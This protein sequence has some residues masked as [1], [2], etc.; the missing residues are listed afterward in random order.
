MLQV[1]IVD[2]F[3]GAVL[4]REGAQQMAIDRQLEC[5]QV[6]QSKL[7]LVHPWS[8]GVLHCASSAQVT[9]SSVLANSCSQMLMH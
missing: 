3:V 9:T 2:S 7:G 4:D 1:A 5:L 8:I 6:L